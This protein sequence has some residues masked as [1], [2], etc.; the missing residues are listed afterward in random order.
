MN[1]YSFVYQEVSHILLLY[2][3]NHRIQYYSRKYHVGILM[4]V[5]YNSRVYF[6]DIQTSISDAQWEEESTVTLLWFQVSNSTIQL[7]LFRE[8]YNTSLFSSTIIIKSLNY[9]FVIIEWKLY[10]DGETFYIGVI[11][12]YYWILI[13]Q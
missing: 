2:F 13:F 7:I 5:H 6:Y 1:N 12:I 9:S 11:N 10:F 3:V 4:H 8:V